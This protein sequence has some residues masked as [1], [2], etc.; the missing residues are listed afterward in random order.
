MEP[1][2]I[3]VVEARDRPLISSAAVEGTAVFSRD[4]EKLGTVDCLMFDK[5]RGSVA[6]AVL[7]FGGFLGMGEKRHPLPW[8]SLTYDK[9]QDGYLID[10]SK[11]ELKAA[12]A[13]D[14][15]QYGSL[16]GREYDE[17]VYAHYKAL[18]YWL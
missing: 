9:E 11:D 7:A 5:E 12:P 15:G 13:L 4:G 3:S 17:S 8:S 10:L 1:V 2:M 6:Y 16:G 18:P 14:V